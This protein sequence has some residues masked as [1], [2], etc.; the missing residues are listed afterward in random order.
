MPS[1]L[2]ARLLRWTRPDKAGR[3]VN[4]QSRWFMA[5]S[6][7]LLT[8]SSSVLWLKVL[9]SVATLLL[10]YLRYRKR[11]AS[12]DSATPYSLRAKALVGLAV[13]LSF[14]AFHSFGKPQGGTFVHHGEMFHYY[15]GSKYFNELGYYE[16]YNAVIAADAEQDSALAALPFYTDLATYQNAPRVAALAQA[17]RVKGRFSETRWNAFKHDVSYFKEL[18]GLP[19]TPKLVFFLMDHGYNASPVSTSLLSALT[20]IVP[21]TQLPLL[22]SLDVLLVAAMVAV[23]F[24]TF[25]LEMGALFSVYFFANVLNDPGYVSGGLLRYDWLFCCVLAVCLLEKK[26]HASSAFFLAVAAMTRLFP[27]VMF[28]GMLL[29]IFSQFKLAR[30]V[31]KSSLRFVLTAGATALALF[32]LPALSFGSVFAPWQEFSAKTALHDRGVYV[33]HLGLRG[34]VLFEPSHLSLD[35]FVETFNDGQTNDIVR[36]WQDIKESEFHEKRPVIVFCSLLAL[37]G[38]TAILWKR[39]ER[40]IEGL[41]WPLMLVYVVS[42]PSHYYYAFLCLFILLFFG[43]KNSLR[44]LVPLGL[45]LVF[46]IGALVTDSFSPSPIVFYTLVNIYLFVCFVAIVGFELYANAVGER[47]LGTVAA[48]ANAVASSKQEQPKRAQKKPRRR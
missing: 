19:R 36:H 9:L 14:A 35:K 11:A 30:S 31:E 40:E 29:A 34:M 7:P 10:L 6:A 21:V 4:L 13:V 16:L 18:T 44:S 2:G 22:A 15:L 26:R 47:P 17:E 8:S 5:Q 42:Y 48:S 46:N 27:L 33:N 41:L 1:M 43:R 24:G 39:G 12:G 32:L 20:N 37:V 3:S 23:V 38:L 25:G 28:Y 45:L